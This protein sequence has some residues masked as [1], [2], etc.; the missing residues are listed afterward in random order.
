MANVTPTAPALPPV[1]VIVMVALPLYGLLH[2]FAGATVSIEGP[3]K[4]T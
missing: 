2:M 3:P 4:Y 1:R